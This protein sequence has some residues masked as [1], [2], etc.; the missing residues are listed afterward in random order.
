MERDTYS[1]ICPK[2]QFF[3]PSLVEAKKIFFLDR[4]GTI[5]KDYGYSHSTQSI[6]LVEG[7]VDILNAAKSFGWTPVVI[8]NQAGIAKGLFREEQARIFNAELHKILKSESIALE[9]FLFCPHD[10]QD[11]CQFRKPNPGMIHFIRD[12]LPTACFFFVGNMPTDEEAAFR[13]GILYADVKDTDKVL[14]ELA[15]L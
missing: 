6:D 13:A 5:N 7:I 15:R 11:K 10:S 1:Q 14:I 12:M 4:D 2:L 3:N 8:S 9:Y